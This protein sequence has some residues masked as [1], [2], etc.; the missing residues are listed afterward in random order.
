MLSNK[1]A[2]Y[3]NQTLA[4]IKLI[5][6]SIIAIAGICRLFGNWPESRMNWQQP[7]GGTGGNAAEFKSYSTSILLVNIL[8]EKFER[9]VQYSYIILFYFII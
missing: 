3:I 8:F 4:I 2:N 5:T 6:Y 7:L 9:Y 1:W